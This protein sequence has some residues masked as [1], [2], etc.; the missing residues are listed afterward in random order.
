M[1]EISPQYLAG[2]ID[3]DGSISITKRHLNRPKPNYSIMIQIGWVFKPQSENFMK[4]MVEKYG[5]SYSIIEPR[6]T[7]FSKK[8]H[9]KYCAYA[10]SAVLILN[11]IKDYLLLK[12]MQADNAL[13]VQ[14]IID[15]Y[16]GQ[17]RPNE[18]GKQLEELYKNNLTLND[19]NGYHNG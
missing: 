4:M 11:D 19:K 16:S 12:K 8:K 9:I 6:G 2:V 1:V 17:P 15:S 13:N 18:K 3:S 10:S 5:G 7:T 14:S